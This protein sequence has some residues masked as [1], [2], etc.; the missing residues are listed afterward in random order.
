[1]AF[2]FAA[3][4]DDD[5]AETQSEELENGSL[6]YLTVSIKGAESASSRAELTDDDF[7]DGLAKESAVKDVKFYFF[8]STGK[9]Q[10]K[11][12][13]WKSNGWT[14]DADDSNITKYSVS[15]VTV[16]NYNESNKPAKVVTVVNPPSDLV[17]TE[18][19]TITDLY[20]K[21]QNYVTSYSDDTSTDYYVMTTT[22]F[23]TDLNKADQETYYYATDL[24]GAKFYTKVSD[25]ENGEKV[26]IYVERLAVKA[27]TDFTKKVKTAFDAT[28]E[29]QKIFKLGTFDMDGEG[30]EYDNEVLY[31]KFLNWGLNCLTP[32]SYLSKHVDATWKNIDTSLGK[33]W[34]WNDP[35]RSRSYWGMGTAYQTTSYTFPQKYYS[36]VNESTNG[37]ATES[38]YHVTYLPGLNFISGNDMRSL[39]EFGTGYPLYCNE[40]T[41]SAKALSAAHLPGAVTHVLLL[42]QFCDAN[43]NL[44]NT[45]DKTIIKYNSEYYYQSKLLHKF[46]EYAEGINGLTYN[47]GTTDV[48]LAETDLSVVASEEYNGRVDIRL[49]PTK[50]DKNS[51][52]ADAAGQTYTYE[53]VNKKLDNYQGTAKVYR[54][55]NGFMYYYTLIRHL[56]NTL[57]SGEYTV[58]EAYYG[59]VR[60]HVYNVTIEGF[61]RYKT[62][63]ATG[64]PVYDN[65]G[66]PVPDPDG[67]PVGPEGPGDYEPNIDPGHGIDDPDEPIIPNDETD[68]NYYIGAN[69]N[70]LSWRIVNQSVR[71]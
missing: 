30:D 46:F 63:P 17:M 53:E 71:L 39:G 70:I 50:F 21:L 38:S 32:K 36:G 49:N 24:S 18:A 19:N 13:V 67:D 27:T 33:D 20:N 23:Y 11:G 25:A 26:D 45:G 2:G 61:T 14:T 40:N 12:S 58:N 69:V 60:N 68:T 62:D 37:E 47:N 15:V 42:A 16:P 3:C 44:V 51:T 65:E 48:A 64:E 28:Y 56:N 66:N 55:T 5:V 54:Y 34:S 8:S 10:A 6:A 4:S 35:D 22:S 41:Q 57:S 9:F 31:V 52:F 43:G 7:E 1:M 59:V 29:G